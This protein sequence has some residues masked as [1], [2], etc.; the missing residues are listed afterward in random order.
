M[1]TALCTKKTQ[2]HENSKMYKSPS[3]MRTAKCTNHPVSIEQKH[4]QN[5]HCLENNW[6]YKTPTVIRTADCTNT[7]C[8]E[9]NYIVQNTYCHENSYHGRKPI[10]MRT[11][12]GQNTHCHDNSYIER[13][14]QHCHANIWMYKT[15]HID[16]SSFEL[17]DQSQLCPATKS[18]EEMAVMDLTVDLMSV[19]VYIPWV[20]SAA[21]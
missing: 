15:S 21:C 8:H 10:V 14:K 12:D 3:V 6:V 16:N 7:P 2:C 11:V 18:V 17:G 4:V 5:I 13:R 1:G 19:V 9:N 20:G